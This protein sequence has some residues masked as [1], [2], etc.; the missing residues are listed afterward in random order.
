MWKKLVSFSESGS[1]NTGIQTSDDA[2][3]FAGQTFP[4]TGQSLWLVKMTKSGDLLWQQ[5]LGEHFPG[6]AESM[7]VTQ[8]GGVIMAGRIFHQKLGAQMLVL[9][10]DIDG[11][12]IWHQTL[13]DASTDS[14]NSVV[15]DAKG[16]VLVTGFIS[17]HSS[18]V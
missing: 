9:K 2:I 14:A 5:H 8:D 18:H 11:R 7:V 16:A 1:L 12:P 15:L 3:L 13:G 6:G 4:N 10:V 17:N